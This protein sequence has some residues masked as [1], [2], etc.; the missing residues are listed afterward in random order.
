MPTAFAMRQASEADIA[1]LCAMDHIA[2]H[3][4]CRRAFIA[5]AVNEGDCIVCETED[6]LVGYAVLAYTFFELGFVSMLYVHADHRRQG[7]GAALMRD[8][9]TRCTTPKLFTSTNLSN[10]PMQKLLN[11]LGYVLAGVVH[12]LDEADPELFYVRYLDPNAADN[13]D[14]SG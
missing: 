2:A 11:R 4:P 1:A 12:H 7:V 3:D 10:L 8:L 13:D 6:G 5:R 14:E 9:E